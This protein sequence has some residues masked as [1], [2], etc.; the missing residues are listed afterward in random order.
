[1]RLL[2]LLMKRN[3]TVR[4]DNP[5]LAKVD[6]H[7][8]VAATAPMPRQRIQTGTEQRSAAILRIVSALDVGARCHDVRLYQTAG[9]GWGAVLH[10]NFD[11]GLP[12]REIHR[13]TERIEDALRQHFPELEYALIQAE[14]GGQESDP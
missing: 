10:C 2:L 5:S 11:P 12:M 9:E 6:M 1:M 3:F 4:E 14:P 7:I 13:R 8:E